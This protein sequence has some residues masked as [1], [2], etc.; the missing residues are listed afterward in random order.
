[1]G[2]GRVVGERRAAGG[3]MCRQRV[4]GIYLLQRFRRRRGPNQCVTPSSLYGDY[5]L[6]M[7]N[8]RC[9]ILEELETYK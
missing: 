2:K 7:I 5:R 3:G 8:R 6:E 4:R 1:M 9:T